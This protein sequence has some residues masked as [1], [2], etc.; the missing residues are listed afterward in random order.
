[1]VHDE[2]RTPSRTDGYV[3]LRD[4]AGIGDGRT[5]ALIARDG[6]ID[7]LPLPALHTPPVFSALLDA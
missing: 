2:S 7:W 5:V 6:Q 4:Y 3:P 1:M